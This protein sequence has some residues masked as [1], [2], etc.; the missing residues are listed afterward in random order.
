M[1]SLTQHTRNVL[2]GVDIQ[3]DFITGTLAVP[4]GA[5]VID[6]TNS[7]ARAVRSAE[8]T[9]VFTRD[10][11]PTETPHFN[12][13]PPHCVADT[14]GAEFAPT[15]DVKETDILISKGTGL[16][17]GY[18]G[19]DGA[20]GN[21]ETLE[22]LITPRSTK[23]TVRV[24]LGG[25]ATDYCVKATGIDIATYFED[26]ARVTTYLL[27]DATRAVA[28]HQADEANAINAL[29]KARILAISSEEAVAM[30]K[31]I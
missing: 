6:P 13:W 9:V 8:G 11:H 14:L 2:V 29:K 30:I 17:D 20:G 21:G 26:D 18:S 7:V 5:S 27:R 22:A 24:F 19:W 10:W 28:L 23:E 1:E 12:T 3:N 4:D 15:L 25:L 16:T 31:G